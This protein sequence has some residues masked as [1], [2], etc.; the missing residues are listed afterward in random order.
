MKQKQRA[1]ESPTSS[2]RE[3]LSGAESQHS[4]N[5]EE[6]WTLAHARRPTINVNSNDFRVDIL[7][8]EGKLNPEEFLD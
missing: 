4:I 8:F 6:P 3:Y 5:E 1:T 2:N 7:E